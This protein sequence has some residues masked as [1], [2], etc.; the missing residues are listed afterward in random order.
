VEE[1]IILAKQ[2]ARVTDSSRSLSYCQITFG[3]W[4]KYCNQI[5]GSHGGT[6]EDTSL[7]VCH[8][9]SNGE[10]SL[11]FEMKILS[12]C[13]GSSQ[14]RVDCLPLNT[15]TLESSE[16]PVTAYQSMKRACS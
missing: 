13:L 16:T 7:F 5:L 12:S 9:V 6:V 1:R 4:P 14:R 3:S 8:V 11:T 2:I 15:R 10:Q